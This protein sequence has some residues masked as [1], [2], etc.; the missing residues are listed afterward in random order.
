M[1]C[2]LAGVPVPHEFEDLC[3]YRS[4]CNKLLFGFIKLNS[5]FPFIYPVPVLKA[6]S[7]STSF[8]ILFSTFLSHER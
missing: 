7:V 4:L 6:E 5:N 3:P 8:I 1:S 2:A